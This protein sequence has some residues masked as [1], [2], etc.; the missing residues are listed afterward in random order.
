MRAGGPVP[1]FSALFAHI[2]GPTPSPVWTRGW[3]GGWPVRWPQGTPPDHAGR[4]VTAHKAMAECSYLAA[5]GEAIVANRHSQPVPRM[6]KVRQ[7]R[8]PLVPV[9]AKPCP[10]PNPAQ[11]GPFWGEPPAFLGPPACPLG[12]PLD[13]RQVAELIG[14]SPWT[15]RQ[16]LI[17][18]GLP[19]FRFGASG[20]L[21]FYRDQVVRWIENQQF[22]GGQTT[23]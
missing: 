4:R 14:C 12:L 21:I 23:S 5:R 20:K 11:P 13:L 10:R 15:V 17:P 3:P 19:H 9:A 1:R 6:R 2:D 8:A 16:T 18:R 7:S 22:K